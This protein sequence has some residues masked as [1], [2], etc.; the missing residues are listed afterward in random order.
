MR[1]T[2]TQEHPGRHRAVLGTALALLAVLAAACAPGPPGVAGMPGAAPSPHQAWTPPPE[3]RPAPAKPVTS[4]TASLPPELVQIAEHLTLAKVVALALRDNP[5]T[6]AAWLQSRAAADVYGEQR[7]ALFPTISVGATAVSNKQVA[8]NVRFGGLRNQV[9]PSVTLSYLLFDVGGR[10]GARE[11]AKEGL[12]AA[13]FNHDAVIQNT[14]LQ[15]E[16]AYFGYMAEQALLAA[17]QASV[18]EAQANLESAQHQHDVG[19]ATIADVLQARTAL[20][21]ARLTVEQTEGTLQAAKATLAVSM[22]LPA[23]VPFDV[24]PPADSTPVGPVTESVDSLI[25]RAV[26]SRPDLAAAEARAQGARATERATRSQS[27]PS[28]SL[29]GTGGQTYSDVSQFSGG[30]YSLSLSLS[31][32]IFDGGTDLY[33]TAAARA[34]ARASQAQAEGLRQQVIQQVFTSYYA[35]RTATQLAHTTDDLLASAEQSEQVARGRYQQGVGTIIDLLTA[36]QALA[37]ARAQ[38]SQ[39]RWNWL[40]SLAQL[41]HDVG[42]LGVDGSADLAVSPDSTGASPR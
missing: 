20:S 40:A 11:A 17:D 15:A 30:N 14:V 21:Q 5:A 37:S 33:A 16:Q 1:S 34:N 2:H 29:T 23:N 42:V 6:R 41:S 39:A 27:F 31:V 38:Q 4:S 32:P 35:L 12:F 19:L 26:Q 25:E 13:G 28:L 18:K 8:S 10:S 3:A 9:S 36:Q 7:G 24:A 22:G